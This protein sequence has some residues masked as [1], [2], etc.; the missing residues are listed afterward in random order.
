[1]RVADGWDQHEA[2]GH[3]VLS[4]QSSRRHHRNLLRERKFFS[5]GSRGG[6]PLAALASEIL[7]LREPKFF[8]WRAGVLASC[9]QLAVV[10]APKALQ[11]MANFL[12]PNARALG[13]CPR[14]AA[15]QEKSVWRRSRRASTGR[16]STRRRQQ[17]P[18]SQPSLLALYHA[19]RRWSVDGAP[20][21]AL[22]CAY[23]L[24]DPPAF[25]VPPSS[26]CCSRCW[27]ASRC[28]RR[29]SAGRRVHR[30][31]QRDGS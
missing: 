17:P 27:R 8:S 25:V 20:G 12:N 28:A 22:H 7:F 11:T 3:S 26:C 30:R 1:M 18:P 10:A 16:S 13:P 14:H 6:Y 5:R 9:W 21:R 2:L 19:V 15:R 31:Q 4:P 24:S 23:K 29:L